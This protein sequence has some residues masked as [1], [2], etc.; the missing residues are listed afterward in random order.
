MKTENLFLCSL[1]AIALSTQCQAQ[2]KQKLPNIGKSELF[3]ADPTIV[4]HNGVY[5]LTGTSDKEGA[6]RFHLYQSRNLKN[7]IETDTLLQNGDHTFGSWG[8]WAPQLFQF[9]NR[10]LMLY[11]A[12][13]QIAIAEAKYL[14]DKFRQNDVCPLDESGKNIDPFLFRDDDGT[15][16]LYHVRF[17]N[18]N[19]LWVAEFDINNQ[20]LKNETLQR[21]FD[22]TQPWERTNAHPVATVMEGPTVIKKGG[23]YYLFYSAN[24]FESPDYAVGFAVADTPY[25]P[26]RKS[27][28]NPII[29]RS[30][31]QEPGSGHGDIFISNDG[32]LHY[33]Y[34]IH[35]STEQATPR[36]TRIIPLHSRETKNGEYEFFVNPQEIIIPIK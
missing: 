28:K 2:E 1:I 6:N 13:E 34:H 32:L 18:G 22:L 11:T 19:Y 35:Y 31:M 25:G 30:N 33:V 4:V 9:G 21:C 36:R 12:N 8:F 15:C 16:Y 10:W 14:T 24:H 17:D 29:H 3:M 23:K 26:W 5:Y 27:E 7:W 20:R